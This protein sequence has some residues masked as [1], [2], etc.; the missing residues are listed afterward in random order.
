MVSSI[1]IIK[2]WNLAASLA[3]ILWALSGSMDAYHGQYP[4]STLTMHT[5][6]SIFVFICVRVVKWKP[7]YDANSRSKFCAENLNNHG[8]I[9]AYFAA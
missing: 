9:H 1:K 5:Y 3:T 6:V 4:R 7:S 2:S 8:D